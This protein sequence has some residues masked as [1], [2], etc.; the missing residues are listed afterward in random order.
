MSI[1]EPIKTDIKDLEEVIFEVADLGRA[2]F[3]EILG[4]TCEQNSA[5]NLSS[6]GLK[7]VETVEEK[8]KTKGLLLSP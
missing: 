6:T 2:K 5:I 8:L 4:W 1:L 7:M 3:E